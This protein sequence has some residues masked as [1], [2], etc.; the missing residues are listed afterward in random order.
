VADRRDP[1]PETLPGLRDAVR[2]ARPRRATKSEPPAEH[3]PVARVLV[4]T[5]LAH[6]DRPFDYA[7]PASMAAD[8]VPGARVKVRF[9]GK[10]LDGFVVARA[11]R[12]EHTGTLTPLQ[13]VVSPEPVLDPSVAELAAVLAERYAGTRSDVLRLA[14]PPRHATTE[15]QPS[16]PEEPATV[17]VPRARG[18]WSA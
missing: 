1:A 3:D 2:A 7:V 9:A 13:R 5:P 18:A 8:A 16:T 11:A 4:D 10:A 17:D 14:V 12:T 15:K 6:L